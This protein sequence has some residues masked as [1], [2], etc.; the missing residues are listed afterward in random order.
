VVTPQYGLDEPA[1][2]AWR[3]L[4]QRLSPWRQWIAKLPLPSLS[5]RRGTVMIIR[6][7]VGLAAITVSAVLPL[8]TARVVLA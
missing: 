8:Y 4:E 1:V 5:S 3:N 6:D 7:L 2:G